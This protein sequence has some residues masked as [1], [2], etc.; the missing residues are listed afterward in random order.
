MRSASRGAT[1]F[2]SCSRTSRSPSPSATPVSRAVKRSL[3]ARSST[4]EKAAP[5]ASRGPGRSSQSNPKA[6]C[7]GPSAPS[8]EG[9]R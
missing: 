1:R 3:R 5:A 8:R 7:S 9:S 2:A 4:T 6:K